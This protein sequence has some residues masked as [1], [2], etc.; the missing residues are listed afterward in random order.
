MIRKLDLDS[1]SPPEA[2]AS[3]KEYSAWVIESDYLWKLEKIPLDYDL[4]VDV[5]PFV[6]GTGDDVDIKQ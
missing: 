3:F 2:K 1:V 5:S 6:V 4:Q